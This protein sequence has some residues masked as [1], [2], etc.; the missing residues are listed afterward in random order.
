MR[1]STL[2]IL[3][4]GVSASAS[5]SRQEVQVQ[6]IA[7]RAQ[8]V[9]GVGVGI[10]PA[11]GSPM[12]P[13]GD[14][15]GVEICPLTYPDGSHNLAVCQSPGPSGQEIGSVQNRRVEAMLTTG[16]GQTYYV[17]L[18][19]ERQYGWCIPLTNRASYVGQLNDSSKW[20]ADYQHRPGKGFTKI[21]LRPDGKK[22]V[23]YQIEYAVK[24]KR[25]D[26]SVQK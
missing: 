2:L 5:A 19:C 3:L 26:S 6:V 21:S 4:L 23:T 25:T 17:I 1:I 15:A 22:K 24:V 11:T 8:N 18:G 9:S 12:P 20:L 7:T 13:G 10:G 14:G 16:Q